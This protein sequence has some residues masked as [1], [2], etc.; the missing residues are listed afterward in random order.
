MLACLAARDRPAGFDAASSEW[1]AH[2]SSPLVSRRVVVVVWVVIAAMIAVLLVA[3]WDP[4]SA[5]SDQA[6]CARFMDGQP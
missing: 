6:R 4:C 3:T 2:E 5:V 1:V